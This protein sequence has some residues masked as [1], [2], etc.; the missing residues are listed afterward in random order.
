MRFA[1]ALLLI[2][3]CGGNIDSIHQPL[4]VSPIDSLPAYDGGRLLHPWHFSKP[5]KDRF[6]QRAVGLASDPLCYLGD[7]YFK[8]CLL[9]ECDP[10]D[11]S[12]PSGSR[13]VDASMMFDPDGSPAPE[14]DPSG[15]PVTT[16]PSGAQYRVLHLATCI[17]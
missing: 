14:I 1:L 5:T 8:A 11:F 12:C 16:T 10:A 7:S 17:K 2:A 4:E 15:V 6:P 13:C 3:G 9:Y